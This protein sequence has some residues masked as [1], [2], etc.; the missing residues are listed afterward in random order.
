MAKPIPFEVSSD[1]HAALDDAITTVLT[2]RKGWVNVQPVASDDRPAER[3]GMFGILSP[4]IPDLAL[5]TLTPPDARRPDE[6]AL[7]GVQHPIP[8][9]ARAVL[10]DG[11]L[12]TPETW[13]LAQDAIRR[14]LIL[15][16]PVDESATT[17]AE[18]MLAA[19]TL[20]TQR[21]TAGRWAVTVHAGR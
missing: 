2:D 21:A 5:A 13:R 10:N 17:I 12:V 11:G 15:R 6:P 3:S 4:R 8:T 1:D 9:R 7:L 20:L 19:T 16:V 14:G 18:W